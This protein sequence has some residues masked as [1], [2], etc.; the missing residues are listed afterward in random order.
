MFAPNISTMHRPATTG[1]TENGRSI[2]VIRNALPR[3]SN[4]VMNQ[5]A[6]MPKAAFSGTEMAAMSQGQPDR[7]PGVAVA[8]A[9]DGSQQRRRASRLG[10]DGDQGGEDQD[11]QADDGK[12]DQRPADQRC[13]L[14][15]RA[16]AGVWRCQTYPILRRLQTWIRLMSS[17]M[18]KLISSMA[19]PMAAAAS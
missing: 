9:L 2:S 4:L 18:A 8:E 3:K 15:G 1:E 13:L 7:R 12:A 17:S 10:K 14:G 5:A 19:M 6:A 16:E 11:R